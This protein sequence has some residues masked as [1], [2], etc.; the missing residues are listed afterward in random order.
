MQDLRGKTAVVTGAASGIGRGLAGALA[1]EGMRVGLMDIDGATLAEVRDELA[2]GGATAHV[3]AADVSVPDEVERAAGELERAL[4]PAQLVCNN[5]GVAIRASILDTSF[6]N[7]NWLVAVNLG[8]A[9]NVI[10]AFVP[11]MIAQKQPGHMLITCSMAGLY[12]MPDR[13]N[14]VYSA[15]KMAVFGLARNLRS[16]V[17]AARIGISALCPGFV[18]SNTRRGGEYRPE[19]FG[20]PFHRPDQGARAQQGMVPEQIAKIA[21]RGIKDN[22]FLIISHPTARG[23]ITSRN[24]AILGEFDRWEPIIAELGI[25]TDLHSLP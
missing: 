14:A 24:D 11:R 13:Q 20:G 9:F 15:T 16:E 3:A 25:P 19:R 23:E 10:K 12:E 6:E 4:G 18:I 22:A 17:D 1:A 7:F 5:V 21:V 8:G 2:R